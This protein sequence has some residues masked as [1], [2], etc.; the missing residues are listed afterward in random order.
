MSSAENMHETETISSVIGGRFNEAD[1]ST[2]TQSQRQI[3][4]LLGTTIAGKLEILRVLGNGGMSIVYLA[5]HTLMDRVVAVKV[6][7][8]HLAADESSLKRFRQE[9]RAVSCLDHPNVIAIHDFGVTDDGRPY[10]VMDYVEGKSLAEELKVRVKLPPNEVI[11]L[12]AQACDALEHAHAKGVVHRDLKPG[13]MMLIGPEGPQRKVKIVDF[14]IAKLRYQDNEEANRLTQTGEMFGSPMYMSPEQCLAQPLDARSDVYAIGCVMYETFAGHPPFRGANVYETIYKQINE[15]PAPLPRDANNNGAVVDAIEYIIFKALAKNPLHRY[16]AMTE[17]SADIANASTAIQNG[18][19]VPRFERIINAIRSTRRKN[20]KAQAL[21]VVAAVCVVTACVYGL[22]VLYTDFQQFN[23]IASDN[24]Q[25]L[26]E[27]KFP[28]VLK[29][30]SSS[31]FMETLHKAKVGLAIQ[32][33]AFGGDPDDTRMFGPYFDVG[34]LLRNNGQ[35]S[36]ATEY[37]TKS[38]LCAQ[39]ETS[40]LKRD[41]LIASLY[42]A[43]CYYYLNRSA[44]AEKYYLL[45][46]AQ[47]HQLSRS[48]SMASVWAKLGDSSY[49][50]QK[51]PQAREHLIDAMKVWNSEPGSGGDEDRLL[52]VVKLA[53]VEARLG[54]KYGSPGVSG[55]TKKELLADSR[56]LF[57]EALV[58]LPKVDNDQDELRAEILTGLASFDALDNP[59]SADKEYR[60]ALSIEKSLRDRHEMYVRTLAQYYQFLFRQR[61]FMG[62]WNIGNELARTK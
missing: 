59:A 41:E 36:D 38:F 54:R 46:L 8:D 45:A 33:R 19:V 6:L 26:V 47:V 12:I 43:D 14:G 49:K 22:G 56:L 53:D 15:M 7:R 18:G 51:L 21:K 17:L 48:G 9:S 50:C 42:L 1:V 4:R 34:T 44:D 30:E 27:L 2:L 39:R 32:I 31:D 57:R 60:E 55:V 20:L 61:D 3:D 37:F 40:L 29:H 58:M 25:G 24:D 13:N 62:A 28:D 10:L 35:Y 5:R 16:Q 11:P 23:K 52:A